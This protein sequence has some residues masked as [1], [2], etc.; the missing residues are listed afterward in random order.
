MTKVVGTENT[1]RYWSSQYRDDKQ[2]KKVQHRA[3]KRAWE[4]LNGGK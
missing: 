2:M 1:A 4:M 3:Q